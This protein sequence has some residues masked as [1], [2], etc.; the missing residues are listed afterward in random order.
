MGLDG[1][2]ATHSVGLAAE[3]CAGG[4]GSGPSVGLWRASHQAPLWILRAVLEAPQA[5]R[6][7]PGTG[8]NM[9]NVISS[10]WH[11]IPYI[12]HYVGNRV[13][14]V[15]SLLYSGSSFKS[16]KLMLRPLV[17]DGGIMS[18]RHTITRRS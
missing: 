12:V 18:L 8:E 15:H 7:R 11:P 16:C 17:L 9:E 6:P 5:G 1:L 14:G 13:Y 10:K 4:W 2:G 3:W